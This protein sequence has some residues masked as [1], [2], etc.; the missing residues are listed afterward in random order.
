VRPC[1]HVILEALAE[2]LVRLSPSHRD[3]EQFHEEKDFLASE[4]RRLAR[5][6][7]RGG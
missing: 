4:L 2:R 3:P 5:D 6:L 7:R 1:D